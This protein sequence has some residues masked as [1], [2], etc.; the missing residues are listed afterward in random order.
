MVRVGELRPDK[1]AAAPKGQLQDFF[2][3]RTGL[4]LPGMNARQPARADAPAAVGDRT[5]ARRAVGMPATARPCVAMARN[6]TRGAGNAP[7]Q[8]NEVQGKRP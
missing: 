7:A 4:L 6:W 5:G 2:R 8:A 3:Q 1:A